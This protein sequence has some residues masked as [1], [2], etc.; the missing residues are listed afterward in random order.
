[1]PLRIDK[2]VPFCSVPLSVESCWPHDHGSIL[3]QCQLPW[4]RNGDEHHPLEVDMTGQGK[5]LP[6]YL[7]LQ[8]SHVYTGSFLNL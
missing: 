5:P 2:L 6:L 1:M 3:R 4:V 8:G 7:D